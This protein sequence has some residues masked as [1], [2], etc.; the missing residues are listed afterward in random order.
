MPKSH[1][2][3][4]AEVSA[5]V[6]CACAA[7]DARAAGR[8]VAADGAGDGDGGGVARRVQRVLYST[9]DISGNAVT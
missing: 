9:S 3:L 5:G 7:A 2:T 1:L 4:Y 6:V 8:A